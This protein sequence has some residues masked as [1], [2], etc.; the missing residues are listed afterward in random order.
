M[1]KKMKLEDVAVK[2]LKIDDE[3]DIIFNDA[4][5][6]AASKKI[7][8]KS[9]P[10][11]VVINKEKKVLGTVSTFDIVTKIVSENKNAENINVIQIMVKLRPF[12]LETKIIDAFDIMQKEKIEVV[13]VTDSEGKLLG[14]IT[15]M[16]VFAVMETLS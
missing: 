16:D 9:I 14:V 1:L 4:T 2:H 5:V 12:T 8:E 15:I 13:P 10:D 11:L 7:K 6:L 3:F